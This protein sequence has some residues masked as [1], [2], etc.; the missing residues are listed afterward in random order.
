MHHSLTF[1]RVSVKPYLAVL[2]DELFSHLDEHTASFE[3]DSA[4]VHAVIEQN[5][6]RTLFRVGL[7]CEVPKTT[8]AVHEE[9]HDAVAVLRE[10]FDELERQ[11]GRYKA[12]RRRTHL[13]KKDARRK[14]QAAEV[15]GRALD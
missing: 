13:R 11:L 9:G 2:V 1:K 14:D 4:F 7:H 5:K 8:L 15:N 12:K 10:A 6:A 3:D